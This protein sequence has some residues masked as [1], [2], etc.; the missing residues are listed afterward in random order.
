M[1][2]QGLEVWKGEGGGEGGYNVPHFSG[3]CQCRM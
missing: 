2:P 3:V 1:R